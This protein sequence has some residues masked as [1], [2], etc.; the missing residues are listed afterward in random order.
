[1]SYH[2]MSYDLKTIKQSF[3]ERGIFYTPPELS[4]FLRSLVPFEP[5]RVYDPTCGRGNLLSSFGPETKKY[6][7]DINAEEVKVAAETLTNVTVVAGD[8]LTDPAFLGQRFDCIV[9]NPPFSIKWTPPV[10][11]SSDPRFA[12]APTIPTQSR[13]DYAFLLH[14]LH[15]LANDGVAVVLNFPGILYRGGREGAL[16]R[17]LIECNFIDQVIH[18]PGDTFVDTAIAT[19]VL[20]LRKNRSGT[21]ITFADREHALTRAVPV[22]K[23]QE[24]GYTL[25]VGSYVMPEVEREVIDPI[26]LET[27]ARRS[28]LKKLEADLC[29]SA[30]ASRAEGLDLNEYLDDVLAVVDC[31][32]SE[33]VNQPSS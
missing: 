3:K 5:Q 9:A 33:Y 8:T 7:Q 11:P 15:Y 25:S 31:V 18:I 28:F 10:D 21:D 14:I 23:V 12:D 27:K 19:C 29:M 17:W 16:R 2:H 4:A 6:G 1:M 13:A 32:R 26:A 24:Q 22:S 20:V 30:F